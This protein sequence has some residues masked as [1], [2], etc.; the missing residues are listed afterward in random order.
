MM[1]WLL[2]LLD[3]GAF[4][5]T[6]QVI[7][8]SGGEESEDEWNYS[9]GDKKPVDGLAAVEETSEV[10]LESPVIEKEAEADSFA[11]EEHENVSFKCKA[12]VKRFFL[13]S[14]L[15][16][17][18]LA[19]HAEQSFT[20]KEFVEQ[21]FDSRPPQF[22]DF[23]Q[24]RQEE[25]VEEEHQVQDE[26]EKDLQLT[27]DTEEFDEMSQLNPDAKE[28]VP[29]SPTRSNGDKSPSLCSPVLNP[30]LGHLVSDDAVVSQSPRKGEQPMEDISVPNEMDF[31]LEIDS[32]PHETADFE[33]NELLNPKEAM[34][35]DDKLEQE[36]KDEAQPFFEEEKKQIGDAYKVLE[37][38]FS[39]YSNNFQNGIGDAM[40]RSF[41]EG[42]DDDAIMAPAPERQS[43]VLNS[44]Q[45]IPTFEDEQPEADHQMENDVPESDMQH[46]VQEVV[47]A[48]S[49]VEMASPTAPKMDSSDNFEA[50]HFV[51][52]I[53]SAAGIDES[54]YKYVDQA[55]SP[56]IPPFNLDGIPDEVLEKVE[57]V[58][59]HFMP[60]GSVGV[61][62]FLEEAE[63][64]QVPVPESIVIAAPE[65]P[66]ADV[67]AEV[68]AG[69]AAVALAAGAGAAVAA[70]KSATSKAE[71]KKTEVKKAPVAAAKKA[72]VAAKA[73]I[74]KPTSAPAAAKPAPIVKKTTTT[75]ST[76]KP[77]PKPAVSS[78]AAKPAAS[79]ATASRPKPASTLPPV[80]KPSTGTVLKA[81]TDSS[82]KPAS[83]TATRTSLAAKKPT[84]SV[85]ATKWVLF[86]TSD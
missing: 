58:E 60:L 28:F 30:V 4:E 31:E 32:R 17:F 16:S 73:P 2:L 78:T 45:P 49:D 70:K 72:P 76:T 68:T 23:Q 65:E 1:L 27:I 13:T 59:T 26:V 64:A 48:A 10:I 38:S 75:T 8:E 56:E 22:E 82:A 57:F 63:Q 83:A 62:D 39:E 74:T 6:Q 36:Y 41:Y 11:V 71:P 66:K 52:E 7:G 42:R 46:P 19:T 77:A 35:Q 44:I 43:D 54:E 25:P 53:K 21:E 37:S 9:K 40:N 79:S 80:K 18:Q 85:A 55:L 5:A 61:K 51:E 33:A 34:Q 84:T 12:L 86:E 81:A 14:F 67:V 69:V 15:L 20:E 47:H 3:L 29:V 50:E 24:E